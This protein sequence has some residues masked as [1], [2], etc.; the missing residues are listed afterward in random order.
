MSNL[1]KILKWLFAICLLFYIGICTYMYVVQE[2]LIFKP[3]SLSKNHQYEFSGDFEEFNIEVDQNVKLNALLFKSD[4]SKGL[5]FYLHGNSGSL[6]KWGEIANIYTDLNYDFFV[7]DYRGY[8]KSDSKISSEEQFYNDAKKVYEFI[9]ASYNSNEINIIGY[10]IGTAPAA[11][12]AS[13]YN[14][15]RLI[16]KAPYYSLPDL[17][18]EHYPF[19]PTFLLKYEFRTYEY[20]QKMKAEVIIFHG[21]KDEV[22]D[23]QAS[24]KLKDYFKK[25]D[26]LIT[27]DG[28]KHSGMNNNKDYIYHLSQIFK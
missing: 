7:F 18:S 26:R 20:L 14:P 8:G 13:I 24:E 9:T 19:I 3:E 22:I 28:Q 10:S 21:N 1:K 6:Q 4:A 17:M 25:T 11:M 16:L 23:Y 15:T 12:L 2:N 27:L 5:I